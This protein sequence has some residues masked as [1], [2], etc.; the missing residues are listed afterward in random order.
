MHA[1]QRKFTAVY[2][3]RKKLFFLLMILSISVLSQSNQKR[4]E[5]VLVRDGLAQSAIIDITSDEYGYLWFGTH[6]GLSRYDG[7]EFTN[8][9]HDSEDSTSLSNNTAWSLKSTGDGHLWVGTTEGL[10]KF[11]W[12]KEH[13]IRYVSPEIKGIKISM[14]E[15]WSTDT[16]MLGTRQGIWF[17]DVPNEA[18][19]QMSQFSQFDGHDVLFQRTKAGDLL[20]NSKGIIHLYTGNEIRQL[21]VKGL[22]SVLSDSNNNIWAI[23]REKLLLVSADLSEI[24]TINE[25]QPNSF[26]T[27]IIEGENG[28][29]Y[30][31]SDQLQVYDLNGNLLETH[32]HDPDKAF[33]LLDNAL[34]AIHIGGDGIWWIG[35]AGYGV[36]KYDPN[37]PTLGLL[38]SKVGLSPSLSN[39]YVTSI[40][41]HDDQTVFVGT[42]NSLDLFDAATYSVT[43]LHSE[44]VD[45]LC[46]ENGRYWGATDDGLVELDI[47]KKKVLKKIPLHNM[48]STRAIK[49]FGDD[50][51]WIASG[52]GLTKLDL[53]TETTELFFPPFAAT[54][55]I[56]S[57]DWLTSIHKMENHLLLGTSVGLFS[58]DLASQTISKVDDPVLSK[59]ENSFIKCIEED[60][61]GIIWIGT[62]GDGLFRWDKESNTLGHFTRKDGLPNNVIYGILQDE[63][64]FLWVS[65]NNGLSRLDDTIKKFV[66]LDINSGLQSNEFNTSAYFKSP[67][68]VFYF[69]GVKGLNYFNPGVIENPKRP[70]THVTGFYLGNE[71]TSPNELGLETS[72]MDVDTLVLDY[73]QNMLSFDFKSS[74]YTISTLNQYAY[75]LENLEEDYNYVGNRRFSNYSSLPPGEYVFKVKSS[76]NNGVWDTTP[77]KLVIIITE[78]YWQ[79]TWFKI[80][81]SSIVVILILS[82]T[83]LRIRSLEK[84]EINLKKIVEERTR[85]LQKTNEELK[86]TI[87]EKEDT[88]QKLVQSE[89]MVALGTLSAG[90]GHEI[91][92][93]LNI[94]DQAL[95][96]LENE[97]GD[98]GTSNPQ[99]LATYIKFMR[100]GVAR[101]TQ[102]VKSLSNFSRSGISYSE[103]CQIESLLDDCLLLLNSK[104]KHK[105]EIEK[106]Y[107]TGGLSVKGNGGKLHQVFFNILSNAVQAISRQGVISLTTS[108]EKEHL[109][110]EISD[111]GGGIRPE[112]INRIFDPFFTTKEPGEGTGLG[113]SISHTIIK[114][115]K[116]NLNVKSEINKGTTLTVS[117]P[118]TD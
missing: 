20:F 104:I 87:L 91:N 92:N 66:N 34:S 89:K 112:N 24:R 80:L 85:I 30:V 94:I 10:N 42:A 1:F 54:G 75:Y 23:T 93:P 68:G 11:D 4:F 115:H 97:L 48:I 90:V 7:S 45:Y 59:L 72:I 12:S 52:A 110:V 14:I 51:L 57:G 35:T 103:D 28:K 60:R 47:S 108:V 77:A 44:R 19:F 95:I 69:G 61:S 67:N 73:N 37:K 71:R 98:N 16:L 101:A 58:M 82:I 43:K 31:T 39:S 46:F 100:N 25:N 83:G 56:N 36:S 88:Q 22:R 109:I 74:N 49:G 3:G 113:L 27:K 40:L 38:E 106:K 6:G 70:E 26:R 21:E 96:S 2:S 118:L 55:G 33:S 13:F 79:T 84:K 5:P 63:K 53:K 50:L 64:G 17:F 102:I 41:T 62:S 114:Q 15:K 76:N 29:I 18:F 107:T 99:K 81:V 32:R 117:L 8:F 65:T 111:T 78:P 105:A 116:G 86:K 9:Y